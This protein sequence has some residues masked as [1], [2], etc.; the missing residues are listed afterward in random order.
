M[1]DKKQ[2]RKA[3]KATEVKTAVEKVGA[4]TEARKKQLGS[5]GLRGN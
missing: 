4:A 1:A 3:P 5:N 2:E